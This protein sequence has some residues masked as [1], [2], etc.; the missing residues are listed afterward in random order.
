[1]CF[2]WL[3]L[4]AKLNIS[5]RFGVMSHCTERSINNYACFDDL[6][7]GS[8]QGAALV[9]PT[10][11]SFARR[12]FHITN[13]RTCEPGSSVNLVSGYR[14]D[15]RAIEVRSPPEADV[16]SNLCVQTGSG[17][18]PASC[19]MGTGVPFLGLKRGRGVTLTTHPHLVPMLRMCRSYTFPTKQLRDV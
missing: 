3:L 9:W 19:T 10:T 4:P 5:R 18:H 17:A 7:L 11:S 2:H 14:L 13:C 6:L 16:P 1:V 15:D 12:H 8:L